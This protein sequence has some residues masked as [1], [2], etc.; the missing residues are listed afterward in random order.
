MFNSAILSE[1]GNFYFFLYHPWL[2]LSKLAQGVKYLTCIR[3]KAGSNFYRD[4]DFS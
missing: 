3:E 4:T 1:T 2:L